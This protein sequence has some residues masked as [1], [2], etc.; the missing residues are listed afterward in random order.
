MEGQEGQTGSGGSSVGFLSRGVPALPAAALATGAVT[1][2]VSDNKVAYPS[3]VACMCSGGL[4]GEGCPGD[5]C[6]T[7][8]CGH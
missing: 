7:E 4:V 6:M 2:L 1:R 8:A 5:L 3:C